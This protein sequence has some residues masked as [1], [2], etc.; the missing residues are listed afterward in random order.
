VRHESCAEHQRVMYPHAGAGKHMLFEGSSD[1]VLQTL[2][3]PHLFFENIRGLDGTGQ[4]IGIS[5]TGIDWDNCFFWESAR[6]PNFPERGQPPPFNLVDMSR[7]KIIAY[8]FLG[9]CSLCGMCP[10]QVAADRKQFAPPN[11]LLLAKS[12]FLP[13]FN[14][15]SSRFRL[16][17]I[18]K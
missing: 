14:Q 4:I 15:I 9:D 6:S 1:Q 8:Y 2:D 5:D 7:R 10:T 3:K 13:H 17:L 12:V 18:S 16:I 11:S